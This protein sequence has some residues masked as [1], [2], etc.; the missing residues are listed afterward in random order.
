MTATSIVSEK[1]YG[2]RLHNCFTILAVI[3]LAPDFETD[4]VELMPTNFASFLVE[5][6]NSNKAR[7]IA[8]QEYSTAVAE[9]RDFFAKNENSI[10]ATAIAVKVAVLARY[11][12]DSRQYKTI[13]SIVKKMSYQKP[14]VKTKPD[15]ENPD[16]TISTYISRSQRSYGSITENFSDLITVLVSFQNYDN[17]RQELKLPALQAQVLAAQ[18]HNINTDATHFNYKKAQTLRQENYAILSERAN[19]IKA[20]LL[21]I[22]GKKS[23]IYK[24]VADLSI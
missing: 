7:T 1:T 11:G 14:A 24:Q 10:H 8:E 23:P 16:N 22:Y 20:L 18:Q 3:R 17:P 5:V 12:K 6:A 19:K 21:S 2:M 13:S 4:Q 9:R 15:S